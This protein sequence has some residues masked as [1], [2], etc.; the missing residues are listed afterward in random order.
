[1]ADEKISREQAIIDLQALLDY[2]TQLIN[3]KPPREL[4][5]GEF[6]QY[7]MTA[8]MIRMAMQNIGR[9]LA[10]VTLETGTDEEK[11]FFDLSELEGK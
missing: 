11:P 1:M 3:L 4:E 5:E 7:F 6:V 2:Y 9:T 8:P 10:Y